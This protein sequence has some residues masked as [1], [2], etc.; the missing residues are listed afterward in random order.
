MKSSGC[1]YCATGRPF[2]KTSFVPDIRTAM[3]TKTRTNGRKRTW[4]TYWVTRYR[5]IGLS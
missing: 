1:W 4:S 2:L 3:F 5:L